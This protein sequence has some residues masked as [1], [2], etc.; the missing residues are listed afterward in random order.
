MLYRRWLFCW[1]L[2]ETL[3]V[4]RLNDW[5]IHYLF[6]KQFDWYLIYIGG[7]L[8]K[9]ENRVCCWLIELK[10]Y[11]L[12]TFLWNF[13][14]NQSVKTEAEIDEYLATLNVW[15]PS[16]KH[17]FVWKRH[18]QK[19]FIWLTERYVTWQIS[20]KWCFNQRILWNLLEPYWGYLFQCNKR[21]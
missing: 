1:S 17:K 4:D 2:P 20:R 13:F 6:R 15:K 10:K 14:K 16:G 18:N 5:L 3:M 9:G 19:E 11:G 21:S 7:Y 12:K 8:H